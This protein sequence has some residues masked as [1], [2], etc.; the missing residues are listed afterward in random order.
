MTGNEL[1]R[2]TEIRGGGSALSAVALLDQVGQVALAAVVPVEVHGHEDARAAELVRALAPQA[3]DLVVGVN[4]V[5]LED[6][7]LHLFGLPLDLLGLGVG[8]LLAFLAAALQ[9]RVQEQ[10]RVLRP[11]ATSSASTTRVDPSRS[12]T[13]SR[14]AR[15]SAPGA[16]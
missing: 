13:K 3:R 4:L 7:E 16:P 11:P 1:G 15:S 2:A 5:V 10:G 9:L 6:R 14:M 8:L 12:R